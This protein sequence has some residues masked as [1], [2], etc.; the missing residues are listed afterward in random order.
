[1]AALSDAYRSA[2]DGLKASP[3]TETTKRFRTRFVYTVKKLYSE[4]SHTYPA[5]FAKASDWCAWS[6]GLYTLTR[7]TEDAMQG[8]RWD[9]AGEK[10]AAV[11]EH[12][13]RL[14]VET[15]VLRTNDFIHSFW[16]EIR[17]DSPDASAL[18]RALEGL[19]K[20]PLSTSAR[21]EESTFRKALREWQAAVIPAMEDGAVSKEEIARLRGA[22]E[23]LY[24]VYGTDFE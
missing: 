18:S 13:H 12:V 15:G 19:M 16:M 10:L 24:T 1:M 17:R 4:T 5:R 20:A 3:T 7:T 8:G 14:H 22:T 6:K 23:P 2:A 11:R 9:E 21:R